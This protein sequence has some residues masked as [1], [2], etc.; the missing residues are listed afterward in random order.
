[1]IIT[2]KK[3]KENKVYQ[4]FVENPDDRKSR[5]SFQKIYGTIADEA[6]KVHNRLKSFETAGA[7]NRIYGSTTN[8]IELKVGCKEKEP[9]IFKKGD[10][11]AISSILVDEINKHD[12]K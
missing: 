9:Q 10:F 1:M 11:D 3:S 7:Y 2:F 5:R 12:Y 6:L 8:R 4:E